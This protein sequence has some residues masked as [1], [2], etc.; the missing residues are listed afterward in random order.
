[1][2]D[3]LLQPL[4]IQNLRSGNSGVLIFIQHL[5]NKISY[6]GWFFTPKRIIKPYAEGFGMDF[7]ENL[8]NILALVGRLSGD[9]DVEYYAE[10]PNVTA[11]IVVKVLV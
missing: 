9:H 5:L 3:L 6:W 8:L 4:V 10:R 7:S 11:F 2:S 1:M